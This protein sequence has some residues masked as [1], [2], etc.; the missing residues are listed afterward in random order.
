MIYAGGLPVSSK[1]SPSFRNSTYVVGI[2]FGG[3]GRIEPTVCFVLIQFPWRRLKC[4]PGTAYVSFPPEKPF[5]QS[6]SPSTANPP[7]A[8]FSTPSKGNYILQTARLTLHVWEYP[9]WLQ[10]H[11]SSPWNNCCPIKDMSP[12]I[13][14]P[15]Y[16][17]ILTC[18]VLGFS[19]IGDGSP[20][21]A[22]AQAV[23]TQ[24]LRG[25]GVQLQVS[26]IVIRSLFAL[27]PLRT[28]PEYGIWEW[29]RIWT[30]DDIVC[31]YDKWISPLKPHTSY[32]Y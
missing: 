14:K 16:V 19:G 21:M 11:P 27:L 6:F 31:C 2:L 1:V 8:L 18:V 5:T 7:F 25:S 20:I 15:K 12:L 13:S 32:H 4:L 26:S 24:G 29:L 22:H 28:P 3:C 9:S 30:I 17:S 10:Q 23:N